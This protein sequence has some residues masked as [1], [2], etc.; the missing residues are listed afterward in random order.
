[1]KFLRVLIVVGFFC[2]TS[3]FVRA[4]DLVQISEFMALNNTSLKDEDGSRE[5]WIEI[6]NAGTNTVNLAGWYLTD[7]TNDLRKWMFP[8]VILAPDAYLIV[9]ASNKDRNVGELH[10]NFKL[11]GD[12]EYLALVRSNGVTVASEFF[13]TFP[14][15]APDISYG[16]SGTTGQA[17]FLAPG[18]PAKALVPTSNSLEDP[19][20]SQRSR[21][22]TLDGLDDSA[23]E[24]GINRVR[25]KAVTGL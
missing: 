14:I 22:W 23:L 3:P 13:P 21:P 6:H 24:S 2:V 4:Q 9:F 25:Y 20:S 15:Q 7:T 1:M 5:D 16:L 12:G 11:S 10:T 8:S 19:P 18:A 17:V